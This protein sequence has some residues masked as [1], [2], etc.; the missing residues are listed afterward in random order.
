MPADYYIHNM[1]KGSTDINSAFGEAK[2]ESQRRYM[3]AQITELTNS[4]KQDIERKLG[5]VI[6]TDEVLKDLEKT[7]QIAAQD[8]GKT[9]EEIVRTGF[10]DAVETAGIAMRAGQIAKV[11]AALQKAQKILDDIE[12]AMESY[13]KAYDVVASTADKAA[14]KIFIENYQTISKKYNDLKSLRQFD[15]LHK[16]RD[17]LTIDKFS[18]K[19]SS[20][21][22][23]NYKKM[24]SGATSGIMAAAG[25]LGEAVLTNSLNQVLSSSGLTSL[26]GMKLSARGFGSES[27]YAMVN[28]KQI[29]YKNA[30][31]DIKLS[32]TNASGEI[33]VDL[34]GITLKRTGAYSVN[35]AGTPVY[36]VHIKTSSVGQVLDTAQIS[37]ST[38]GHFYNLYANSGRSTPI[39]INNDG[40]IGET[41]IQGPWDLNQAYKF[42]YN[43][44]LLSS[45]AGNLTTQDFAYF[46]VINKQVYTMPEILT[47]LFSGKA[48]FGQNNYPYGFLDWLNHPETSALAKSQQTIAK[49]H[50]EIFMEILNRSQD[51]MK[52]QGI[53]RSNRV[54]QLMYKQ[55]MVPASLNIQIPLKSLIK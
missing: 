52:A 5:T 48:L 18:S 34:P 22:I 35:E 33:V 53:E 50:T 41:I 12:R 31:T 16:L 11:D 55:K 37:S 9:L 42:M 7:I 17:Y 26:P 39:V 51:Y 15:L 36:T 13:E 44:M 40:T 20:Q 10:N 6:N 47:D 32:I 3:Q 1:F 29:G 14:Q 2:I 49:E 38:I 28:G 23:D 25:F 24:L 46:L 54:I 21:D 19:S 4:F 8:S 43:A 30:T 27:G 45:M